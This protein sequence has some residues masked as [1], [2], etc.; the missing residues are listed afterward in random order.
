MYSATFVPLVDDDS[1]AINF[2]NDDHVQNLQKL[3]L[4]LSHDL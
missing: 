1:V 3:L 4:C 2:Q